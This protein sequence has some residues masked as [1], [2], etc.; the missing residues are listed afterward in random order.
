MVHLLLRYI[1]FFFFSVGIL[2]RNKSVSWGTDCRKDAVS[3][4]RSPFSHTFLSYKI[5]FVKYL[6]ATRNRF[7]GQTEEPE[8]YIGGLCFH[9]RINEIN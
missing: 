4:Y 1:A 3:D 7:N 5:I 9:E 2:Y 6:L 8:P